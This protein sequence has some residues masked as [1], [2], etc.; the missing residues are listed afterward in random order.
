MSWMGDILYVNTWTNVDYD[1]TQNKD[2]H[3]DVHSTACIE[4]D[5]RD[6]DLAVYYNEHNCFSNSIAMSNSDSYD[7]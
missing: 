4:H 3:T 7:C 5:Y 1:T 6:V 2:Q